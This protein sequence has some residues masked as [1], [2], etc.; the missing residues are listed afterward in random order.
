LDELIIK[1]GF[2]QKKD[3]QQAVE[4]VLGK[5]RQADLRCVVFFVCSYY[6]QQKISEAI[7]ACKQRDE[8]FREVE[9]VGCTSAGE[10][11]ERGFMEE[12]ITAMSFA[13]PD[14]QVGVGVGKQ[15][16]TNPIGAAKKAVEKACFQLGV[17]VEQL[18]GDE[19]TG[20]VLID[21]LQ[22]VEEYVMLGISKIA[23]CL[24]VAGGSAGDD[25]DFKKTIIHARGKTYENAMVV[26]LF[27]S[28]VPVRIKQ[29]SKYLPTMK[30]LRVTKADLDQRIVFEFNGR[31]ATLEY[32]QALGVA[33][34][35]LSTDYFMKHP[36]ALDCEGNYHIRSIQKVMAKEGALMLFSHISEGMT[37]TVM[38]PGDILRESQEVIN[39]LQQEMPDISGI[40]AF[41][42]ILR[43]RELAQAG[44]L[45]K[46]AAV[47]G[48][49]PLIGFNTYGEQYNG[50]HVNQTMTL[51]AFG[52]EG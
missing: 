22:F 18:Q 21:G 43:Y 33:V 45:D 51:I 52:R 40:I 36:L 28:H 25:S 29:T 14:L 50:M 42:C 23:R 1:T 31:P 48:I 2:S 3:P 19:F 11:T 24:P 34:E 38:Q 5:I 4:E 46:L 12:S 37:V 10:F 44:G 6:D 49:A 9:F 20:L 13:C 26:L 41:N 17:D 16:S 8:L 32:A 30:K 35:D 47:V 39:E 7:S 27:R 15:I